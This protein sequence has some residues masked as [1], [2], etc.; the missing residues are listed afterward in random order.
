M[1][2]DLRGTHH[3]WQHTLLRS[4][5][6]QVSTATFTVNPLLEACGHD[7]SP[8]ACGISWGV[9]FL[10]HM[11]AHPQTAHHLAGYLQDPGET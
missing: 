9:P 10:W 8:L 6:D 3:S 7:A 2:M 1:S 11:H 4:R 5:P